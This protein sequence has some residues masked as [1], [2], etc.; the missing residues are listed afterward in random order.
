[1]VKKTT[2]EEVL[3]QN[4]IGQPNP[5]WMFIKSLLVLAAMSVGVGAVLATGVVAYKLIIAAVF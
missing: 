2:M 5:I 4:G 1:M 3:R